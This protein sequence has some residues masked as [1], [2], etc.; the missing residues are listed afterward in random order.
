MSDK[1]CNGWSNYETWLVNLWFDNQEY[2]QTVLRQFAKDSIRCAE[3]H[4]RD[5]D[6]A[7]YEC[8]KMIRN[9]VEEN[10][11]EV[12]GMFADLLQ[13]ALSEVNW[14]EIAEHIVDDMLV[15]LEVEL[16]E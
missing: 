12:E 14:Y 10:T 11:P 6:N 7:A 16:S 13:S 5:R 3:L 8:S 4:G 15:E 1:K 2:S 9:E